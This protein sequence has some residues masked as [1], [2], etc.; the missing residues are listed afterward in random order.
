M[1][2]K[3]FLLKKHIISYLSDNYDDIYLSQYSMIA[4]SLTEYHKANAFGK[5]EDQIIAEIKRIPNYKEM[6]ETKKRYPE[7]ESILKSY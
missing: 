5:V 1:A 4:F 7:I 2:D 6:I 3:D